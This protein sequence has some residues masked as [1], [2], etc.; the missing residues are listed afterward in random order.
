MRAKPGVQNLVPVFRRDVSAG[1]SLDASTPGSLYEPT[2]LFAQA[3]ANSSSDDV[4]TTW[5]SYRLYLARRE[6]MAA[7]ATSA[8]TVS[9][10][11]KAGAN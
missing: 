6:S 5:H 11:S 4:L 2:E 3:G 8:A 9:V 10:G 1:C 7:D